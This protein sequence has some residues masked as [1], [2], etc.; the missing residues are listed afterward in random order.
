[1]SMTLKET[2]LKAAERFEEDAEVLR[3]FH[4]AAPRHDD[5][6]GEPEAKA[7]YDECLQL[8][9]E[10]R[11]HAQEWSSIEEVDGDTTA[12]RLLKDVRG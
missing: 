3:D 11:R 6:S 9:A 8:A 5:W 10:C 1:M 7:E 2:L 12:E 4:T